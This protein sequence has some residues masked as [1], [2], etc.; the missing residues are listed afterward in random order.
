MKVSKSLRAGMLEGQGLYLLKLVPKILMQTC[1]LSISYMSVRVCTYRN[2]VKGLVGGGGY[3][4]R[5][6]SDNSMPGRND[7]HVL[8]VIKVTT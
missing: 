7:S 6:G 4:D 2:N 1:C 5:R 8:K 3:T